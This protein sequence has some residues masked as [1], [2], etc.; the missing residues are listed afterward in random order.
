LSKAAQ[1]ANLASRINF[2]QRNETI[3]GVERPA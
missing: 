2:D 3:Q 1:H